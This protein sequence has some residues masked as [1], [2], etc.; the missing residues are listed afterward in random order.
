[1]FG[2]MSN[3]GLSK[4]VIN[5]EVPNEQ[6][7]YQLLHNNDLVC[8]GNTD[9]DSGLNASL[10]RLADK[11]QHRVGLDPALVRFKAIRLYVFTVMDLETEL[12]KA[13][14]PPW[15]GKGFGS[16]DPGRERD[17]T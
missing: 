4:D 7:V 6:G 15:N 1:M 13:N 3:A 10:K 14:R 2:E 5:V 11:I 17:T 12:L 16:N 8:L 9:A